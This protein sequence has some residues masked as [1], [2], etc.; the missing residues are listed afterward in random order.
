MNLSQCLA[1]ESRQV[2]VAGGTAPLAGAFDEMQPR[3]TAR[4]TV[5]EQ[6]D[7]SPESSMR[8]TVGFRVLAGRQRRWILGMPRTAR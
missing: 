2:L 8:A 1:A 4:S 7:V 3:T 5:S 6:T